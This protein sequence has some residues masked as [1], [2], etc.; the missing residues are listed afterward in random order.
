MRRALHHLDLW[1]DDLDRARASWGWLLRE[2]GWV[3]FQDWAGGQS[4]SHPDGTYL[5]LE[6]SPDLA[7]GGHDRRRAGLNHLALTADDRDSLDA[8]RAAAEAHGWS[9]LFADRYPHAG[10]AGHTALF[11][12]D[13]QGFEVEVVVP[14]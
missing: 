9:E 7:P 13:D 1:V 3:P 14:A 12:E 6:Q 5:G 4:W 11:L 10:G 8:L 2:L